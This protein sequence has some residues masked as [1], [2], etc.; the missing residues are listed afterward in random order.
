LTADLKARLF[1]FAHAE[2]FSNMGVC[3]TSDV[4]QIAAR[5]KTYVE[6]G[7]H[8]QMGWMAERMNWRGSPQDLWPEA[9]SVIMLAEPYTP[10][11]DPMDVI[12]M[13]A[14]PSQPR[15]LRQRFF[16]HGGGINEHFDL[17]AGCL[18]Q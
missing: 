17:L 13:L 11:H 7:H 8:G 16:H 15:G 10:D 5:L 6:K 12:G 4:P 14:L 3:R 2:G 1:E 9:K 18:L